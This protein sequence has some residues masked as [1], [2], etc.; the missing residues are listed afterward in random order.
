MPTPSSWLLLL[1]LLVMRIVLPTVCCRFG[2]FVHTLSTLVKILKL[3]FGKT[4]DQGDDSDD[5]DVDEY[6]MKWKKVIT[7][8]G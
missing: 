5:W 2:T 3:K 7:I 4:E 1:L 6:D 8:Q